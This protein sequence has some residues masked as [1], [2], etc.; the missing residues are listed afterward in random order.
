[1]SI[2]PYKNGVKDGFWKYHF[3]NG[4]R[5]TEGFYKNG[6]KIREMENL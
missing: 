4:K 6:K 2:G 3:D 1:M 5:K